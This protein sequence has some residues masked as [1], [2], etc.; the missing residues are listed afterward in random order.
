MKS[1]LCSCSLNNNNSH[2]KQARPTAPHLWTTS[3][4]I[5][6]THTHDARS[7]PLLSASQTALWRHC[8]PGCWDPHSHRCAPHCGAHHH[9]HPY[10]LSRGAPEGVC[11]S[12]PTPRLHP[13]CCGL[14]DAPDLLSISLSVG[15]VCVF[16]SFRERKK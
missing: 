5:I 9:P 7:P 4:V 13:S 6:Q 16:F 8:P 12:L 14:E 3:Y 10:R 1:T 11:W 15:L 2:P